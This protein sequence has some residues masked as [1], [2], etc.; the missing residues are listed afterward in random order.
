M[1]DLKN[2]QTDDNMKLV[3]DYFLGSYKE[4][5]KTYGNCIK[6]MEKNKP[7]E[8]KLST[9]RTT[10]NHGCSFINNIYQY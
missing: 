9:K 6:S 10:I 5:K 2:P 8:I 3:K 7:Q 1:E 4:I